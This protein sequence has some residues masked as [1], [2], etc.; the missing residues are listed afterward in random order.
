MGLDDGG[1]KFPKRIKESKNFIYE[2]DDEEYDGF[3][4]G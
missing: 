3:L 1:H 4:W 2:R